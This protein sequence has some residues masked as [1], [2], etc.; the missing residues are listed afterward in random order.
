MK[1]D[2]RAASMCN[3]CMFWT[4]DRGKAIE[5]ALFIC[6]H[7]IGLRLKEDDKVYWKLVIEEI[8]NLK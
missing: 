5:L 6:E 7:T 4:Q 2:E 8:Y 3:Q 1:P